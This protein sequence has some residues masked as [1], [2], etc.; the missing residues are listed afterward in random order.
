VD[1]FG[2]A[3]RETRSLTI[4]LRSLGPLAGVQ[5][6][7]C[8]DQPSEVKPDPAVNPQPGA[9]SSGRLPLRLTA[10]LSGG[11]QAL[12]PWPRAQFVFW[13]V[14]PNLSVSDGFVLYDG[15]Q[16]QWRERMVHL[17]NPGPEARAKS[18][19]LESRLAAILR[20]ERDHRHPFLLQY[21]VNP[22]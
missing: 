6:L 7:V 13:P 20:V 17:M 19:A 21:E 16:A 1:L 12:P 3:N 22:R 18:L 8:T 14:N 15:S 10:V 2:I 4:G 11:V 5:M 9:V